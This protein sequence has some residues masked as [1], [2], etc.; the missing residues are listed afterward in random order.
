MLT[1]DLFRRDEPAPEPPAEA[2]RPQQIDALAAI[3][4][5]RAR[6]V[7]R[8]LTVMGTGLGK[9]W[10]MARLPRELDLWPALVLLD[11]VDL[12]DQIARY[13]RESNPGCIVGIERAEDEAPPDADIVVA[14]V[15]TVG[16]EKGRAAKRLAKLAARGFRL[17]QH[18]ESHGAVTE[19]HVRALR[20]LFRDQAE[21]LIGWTA[22]PLRPDG[23]LLSRI[24]DEVVIERDWEWGINHGQL[25]RVRAERITTNVDLRALTVNAAGEFAPEALAAAVNVGWVNSKILTGIEEHALDDNGRHTP[26]RHLIIF[27]VDHNH[28]H[29]MTR[30]LTDRGH[31]AAEIID[32]TPRYVRQER[33][34]DFREG[35]LRFLTTVAALQQGVDLPETDCVVHAAPTY[36]ML[37][38]IQ[39]NGRGMRLCGDKYLLV[40]DHVGVCGRFRPVTAT[41]A[42]GVRDVDCLGEDVLEVVKNVRRAAELGVATEDGD[43]A[44][45]VKQRLELVERIAQKTVRI[46]TTAEAVELFAHAAIAP[47]VERHSIFPWVQ[48]GAHRYVLRV[49]RAVATLARGARGDWWLHLHDRKEWVSDK[50]DPL[51]A[52]DRAIKRRAENWKMLRRNAGWKREAVT[53]P[54]LERLKALGWDKLPGG[55]TRGSASHLID[56]SA[57]YRRLRR[58]DLASGRSLDG[59]RGDDD[60]S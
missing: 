12:I 9:G 21:L 2:W 29:E 33:L 19:T 1:G 18:D 31:A 20:G 43:T 16:R 37:R 59:G 11:G 55:L 10:L 23:K 4:A 50:D 22:T 38:Y 42:F 24:F 6:G 5:A 13:C 14:S 17:V 47:E 54:Q 58:K 56:L 7:K 44:E 32:S 45:E 30:Q 25:C 57:L 40:L 35:R 34:R 36:S 52:A 8:Q 27:C 15:S 46:T 41:E 60:C 39:R 3:R 51:R 49:G 28:V 48:L 53:L 26:R